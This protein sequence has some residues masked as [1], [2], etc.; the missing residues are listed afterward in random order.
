MGRGREC[1]YRITEILSGFRFSDPIS[2]Q[3]L[4]QPDSFAQPTSIVALNL[5]ESDDMGYV[6]RCALDIS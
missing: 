2:R 4:P 5:P 6:S 1:W 3:T